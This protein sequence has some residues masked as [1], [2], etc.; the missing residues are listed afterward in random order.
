MKK[1]VWLIAA[2]LLMVG[3]MSTACVPVDAP[4]GDA[5]MSSDDGEAMA[6]AGDYPERPVQFVVPW[7]PGDLEDVLTRLIA[8]EMQTQTGVPAAVVN[9]P[10]VW[11]RCGRNRSLPGRCRWP[12]H[13]LIRDRH[14][15]SADPKWQ[16]TVCTRRF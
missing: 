7:P 3:L 2:L 16:R 14:P 9:K 8:E 13:W 10:G 11:W 4:A 15:Y 6:D 12:Y 1:S 5:E